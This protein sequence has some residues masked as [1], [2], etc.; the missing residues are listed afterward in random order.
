[1]KVFMTG[2][3][4][5]I[6][7]VA[8]QILFEHGHEII[9]CDAGYFLP[10][11]ERHKPPENVERQ[12]FKDIRDL[13][14]ED[15]AGC[16]AVI[17]LANL[18]NDPSAEL[19]PIWTEEINHLGSVHLAQIAKKAG[20]SRYVFSSSCSVY[21][22]RGGDEAVSEEA[23]AAPI[24]AYAKAKVLAENGISKLRDRSF[25]PVFLRNSTVFGLSPRL[26]LDLV[27][28][29]LV[30]WAYTTGEVKLL[31]TG[32]AWRP[33]VHT[34]DASSAIYACLEAE[35][36]AMS[37]Q[38]FNVGMDSENYRVIEIAQIVCKAVPGSKVVVA[39]GAQPDKRSYR[40]SFAKIRKVLKKFRPEWTTERG[41]KELY[42]HMRKAG[43]TKADFETDLYYNVRHLKKLMGEGKV[44][45]TLRFRS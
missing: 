9:G 20:A 28:N 23:P 19:N 40:V 3:R 42:E 31:S 12:L 21:G 14:T 39:E 41:A 43:F 6:G 45:G 16:D 35:T 27:V 37:G 13:T 29:N 1:M 4:G 38:V 10:D 18:A 8:S 24:T 11:P 30:G 2:N 26:R 34:R 33:N 25:H 36:D 7:S 32:N 17:D 44:D 22:A 5:Y 15:L